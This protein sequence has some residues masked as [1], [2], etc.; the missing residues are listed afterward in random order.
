MNGIQINTINTFL[1]VT[2]K[3]ISV[4]CLIS[5][6]RFV[7]GT[8]DPEADLITYHQKRELNPD[9]EYVCLCCKNKS[10]SGRQLVAKRSSKNIHTID[11]LK[12]FDCINLFY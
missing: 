9:Y 3:T 6:C 7:H 8:C 10:L 5:C 11:F 4:E 12:L 1:V 2:L